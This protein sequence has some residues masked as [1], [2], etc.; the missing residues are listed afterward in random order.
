MKCEEKYRMMKRS[1]ILFLAVC[2]AGPLAFG[3][4]QITTRREKLKDFTS[5]TTKV[6]IAGNEILNEALRKSVTSH[7]EL[8][9]YEFCSG[10]EFENLKTSPNYYFLLVVK[11]KF[12]RESQP[13]IRALTLVKGG[14]EA[15]G[16]L[17]EM[18][19][20]VTFP[21]CA[22]D[23]PSGRELLLLPAFLD[24]IQKHTEA[25]MH[26]EFKA[27]SGLGTFNRNQKLLKNRSIYFAEADLAPQANRNI[28]K[29]LDEDILFESEDFVNEVFSKGTYNAVV[30][31]V[32]ASSEPEAGSPCYKMLIGCDNHELYYFK[33]HRISMRKGKGFLSSDLK[34]I[35]KI[36]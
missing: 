28:R 1:I 16:G 34:A 36:R 22:S 26:T 17:D 4:G 29:S 14:P 24:I 13:G 33:R 18:L 15:T 11:E 12:R 25:Q 19:E 9:P 20:V 7:W 8:S 32:V 21:L 5:K 3:Q 30:S 23:F 27:Y 6:V 31:Y 35:K 2:L 10:Q